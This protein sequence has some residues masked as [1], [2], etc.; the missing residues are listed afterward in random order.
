M[1][2]NNDYYIIF[3]GAKINR[4]QANRGGLGILFGI[5]GVVL[6]FFLP[7][8]EYRFINYVIIFFFA[9]FGYFVLGPRIFK[10]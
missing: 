5:I 1:K 8:R 6:T 10:R 9:V 2:N 3:M 7:F 4:L